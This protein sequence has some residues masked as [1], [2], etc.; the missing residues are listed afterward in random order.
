MIIRV[1]ALT[2]LLLVAAVSCDSENNRQQK[3][4]RRPPSD[5]TRPGSGP[6]ASGPR[7]GPPSAAP[8]KPA[9]AN[10]PKG[11]QGPPSKG[12]EVQYGFTPISAPVGHASESVPEIQ[13]AESKRPLIIN[14]QS[15]PSA[16]SYQNSN[17]EVVQGNF[18]ERPSF[19]VQKQEQQPSFAVQS[20]KPSESFGS[21]SFNQPVG[22]K[23]NFEPEQTSF[24][25]NKFPSFEGSVISAGPPKTENFPSKPTFA[26]TGFPPKPESPQ[27]VPSFSKEPPSN[28]QGFPQ[29]EV[30]VQKFPKHPPQQASFGKVPPKHE[31]PSFAQKPVKEQFSGF[32]APPPPQ[33]SNSGKR[34]VGEVPF[35]AQSFESKR[36]VPFP[37]Q[38]PPQHSGPIFRGPPPPPPKKVVHSKPAPSFEIQKA[39]VI[40]PFSG[41]P[42]RSQ[43]P[44]HHAPQPLPPPPKPVSQPP[45]EGP[46]PAVPNFVQQQPSLKNPEFDNFPPPNFGQH[47]HQDV[48]TVVAPAQRLPA[49]SPQY[50]QET[51]PQI[52]NQNYPTI[53]VHQPKPQQPPQVPQIPSHIQLQLPSQIPSHQA[54]PTHF[55]FQNTQPQFQAQNNQPQFQ[56]QQ[57]NQPQFQLQNSQPQF[58]LQNSQP[59]FH[60]QNSQ[61]QFQLQSNQPQ[62]QLPANF[63]AQDSK[64]P[65]SFSSAPAASIPQFSALPQRLNSAGLGLSAPGVVSQLG[66]PSAFSQYNPNFAAAAQLYKGILPVQQ[67]PGAGAS[68]YPLGAAGVNPFLKTSA[69]QSSYPIRSSIPSAVSTHSVSGGVPQFQPLPNSLNFPDQD[70]DEQDLA[71]SQKHKK[72]VTAPGNSTSKAKKTTLK[73]ILAE[74]CTGAED[75]GY[76]ASPPRYPTQQVKTVMKQCKDETDGLFE[77]SSGEHKV[78]KRDVE[79][80]AQY[81]WTTEACSSTVATVEPGY[82]RDSKGQWLVVVQQASKGLHQRVD[83]DVCASEGGDCG[84]KQYYETKSLVAWDP[85]RPND[86]PSVRTFKFPSKCDCPAQNKKK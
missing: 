76:C 82:A 20:Q 74:D 18:K 39:S 84:C 68:A 61:P 53:Q 56:F 73:D 33:F 59:Q 37:S 17:Q 58:Q 8:K 41:P 29:K 13:P 6:P 55:Q 38:S 75:F 31:N 10:R 2:A 81:A 47:F 26:P 35:R 63:G 85:D 80:A 19:A 11:A 7:F 57:T 66:L 52:F 30:P 4:L 46:K 70:E 44:V 42:V 83:V 43:R 27:N 9:F 32:P 3:I 62:F 22:A 71:A 40:G 12:P 23:I 15:T 24:G 77:Q 86:C 54:P 78:S 48:K 28:F 14:V 34:V 69:L 51:N 50:A 60:L 5:S 49:E 25:N 1:S 16:F 36:V 21:F 79:P 64:L 65:F 72:Y 67:Y 45:Q